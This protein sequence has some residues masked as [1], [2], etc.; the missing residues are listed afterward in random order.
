MSAQQI[1]ALLLFDKFLYR[2][3]N[4]IRQDQV[5]KPAPRDNFGNEVFAPTETGSAAGESDGWP[6]P[7]PRSD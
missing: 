1:G 3:P 6:F 2:P 7:L 5:L 4:D